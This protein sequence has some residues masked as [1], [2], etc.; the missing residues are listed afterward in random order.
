MSHSRYA[1]QVLARRADDQGSNAV[2][3]Q[4]LF[5]QVA[6]LPGF[7]APQVGGVTDLDPLVVPPQVYRAG[8]PALDDDRLVSG[9]FQ[10]RPPVPAGFGFSIEAGQGGL[11]PD[12][13]PAQTRQR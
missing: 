3:P 11:G 7:L 6:G 4:L 2:V 1:N 9:E 5:Q 10:L 13:L 12:G 8:G